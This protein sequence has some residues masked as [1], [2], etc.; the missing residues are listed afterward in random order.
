MDFGQ[1]V[2]V[3]GLGAGGRCGPVG[4]SGHGTRAGLRQCQ[5]LE[6]LFAV[7]TKGPSTA[8]TVG[9]DLSAAFMSRVHCGRP[10]TMALFP[11]IPAIGGA[12]QRP[13]RSQAQVQRVPIQGQPGLFPKLRLKNSKQRI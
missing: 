5:A 6:L 9:C 13:D 4:R 1:E 3:A 12:S 2:R 8:S 10:E 7:M 11:I